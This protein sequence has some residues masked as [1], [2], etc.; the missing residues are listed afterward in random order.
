MVALNLGHRKFFHKY[1]LTYFLHVHT[2]TMHTTTQVSR[3]FFFFARAGER[4]RDLLFSFIFSF[5]HFTA[6]PQRLPKLADICEYG[7]RCCIRTQVFRVGRPLHLRLIFDWVNL[8]MP[9]SLNDKR[10]RSLF[11]FGGGWGRLSKV[12]SSWTM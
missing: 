1:F 5:H 10:T 8:C 11:F 2:I 9:S 7:P 4:T 3:H 6:E 12:T